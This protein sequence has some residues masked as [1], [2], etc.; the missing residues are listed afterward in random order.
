MQ[1]MDVTFL[2]FSSSSVRGS[3]SGAFL[4]FLAGRESPLPSGAARFFPF[5]PAEGD[6]DED[7]GVSGVVR[8][9]AGEGVGAGEGG[10]AGEEATPRATASGAEQERPPLW[11][12][13]GTELVAVLPIAAAAGVVG[14]FGR[15]RKGAM[16]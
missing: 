10:V 16:V 5:W 7:A 4:F 11:P 14:F 15:A 12:A 1:L 2:A 9:A 6:G 13:A 8:P 3:G